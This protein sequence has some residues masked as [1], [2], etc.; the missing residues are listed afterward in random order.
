MS[1]LETLHDVPLSNFAFNFNLR[2][3]TAVPQLRQHAAKLDRGDGEAMQVVPITPPWTALG[4][5][6]RKL[7]LDNLLSIFAFNFNLRR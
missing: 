6:R 3:S 5:K 7:N 2:R 1:T 4:T